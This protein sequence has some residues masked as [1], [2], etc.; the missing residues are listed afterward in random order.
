V[1]HLTRNR[2]SQNERTT[3]IEFDSAVRIQRSRDQVFAILANFQVYLPRWAK[4]P[5]AAT[6]TVGDGG[7]GSRYTV[8]SRF[9]PVTVRSPYEV[10]RYD[11]PNLIAGTGVAGPVRFRE[12]YTL[13]EED[14]TTTLTQSISATPRG[15]FRFARTLLKA[16]L[17]RLIASD[18]DRLKH[19]V[20]QE[21][22][23]ST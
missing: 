3:M 21:S 23:S 15:P 17:Q 7:V 6:R 19:L 2:V 10:T 11:P 20:E 12:Q 22:A 14:G 18:L 8:T 1:I 5:I 4:G 13:T 9:G 16:Q